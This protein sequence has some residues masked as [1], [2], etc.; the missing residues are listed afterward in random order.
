MTL[1]HPVSFFLMLLI[2][3]MF[4]ALAVVFSMQHFLVLL[5]PV[6]LLPVFRFV[7]HFE[8]RRRVAT[9]KSVV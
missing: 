7:C 5:I 3:A 6:C 1:R 4:L 2:G 8:A 9:D